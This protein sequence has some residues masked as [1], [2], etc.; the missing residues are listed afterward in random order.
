MS[1][2]EKQLKEMSERRIRK[3]QE[4]YNSKDGK[5]Y[6]LEVDFKCWCHSKGKFYNLT[7]EDFKS[8]KKEFDL[9]LNFAL[10]MLAY[11]KWFGY[12]FEYDS[13]KEKWITKEKKGW[14]L[15]PDE[16]RNNNTK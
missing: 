13:N 10:E 2:F 8:Y 5:L 6:M 9:K 11:E 7:E 3:E 12:V 14:V 1:D 16:T 15:N 4:F